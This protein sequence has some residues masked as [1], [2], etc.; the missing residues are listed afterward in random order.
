LAQILRKMKCLAFDLEERFAKIKGV[1]AK[2]EEAFVCPISDEVMEDPVFA[3][4]GHTY[5]RRCIKAW[6]RKH[7]TSPLTNLVLPHKHLVPNHS[8]RGQIMEWR[9]KDWN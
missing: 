3:A 9:S 1:A 5:E 8:L 6:L 2:I 7:D 4:D